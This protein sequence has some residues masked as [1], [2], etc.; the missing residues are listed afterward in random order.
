[1]KVL[2]VN[3]VCGHGGIE[4][5]LATLMRAQREIGIEAD[6]FHFEN[7]GGGANYEGLGK[8]RF[9]ET[10]SLTEMI[11]GGDYDIVHAVTYA[12]HSTSICLRKAMYRGGVVVTSHGIGAY[13]QSLDGAAVVAVS[14]AVAE[15]IQK[16]YARPVRVVC[17]GIDLSLFHPGT[18]RS[19]E[20]P[21]I[22]WVG[23]GSDPHKDAG[24]FFALANSGVLKGFRFVMVDGSAEGEEPANWLPSECTVIRRAAWRDMPDFYRGVAASRGFVVSTSRTEACPMNAIEAQACGCP[25][26][27]PRVGGF[28]EVIEDGKTGFLYDRAEGVSGILK[29]VDLLHAKGVYESAS[30]AASEFAA[31][32]F[33]AKRMCEEYAAIYDEVAK[34]RRVGAV[35]KA[36]KRALSNALYFVHAGRRLL[37]SIKSK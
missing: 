31:R 1:M 24:G 12:A 32:R 18:E 8:V 27:A 15:S 3:L 36:A 33:S 20:K 14:Q 10:D 23:R 11:L 2:H 25:V 16:H 37:K 21:I 22:A 17:N 4:T 6:V 29:S 26:I 30:G 19:N 34:T 35:D 7:R 5:V 28:A 13:E 9:A